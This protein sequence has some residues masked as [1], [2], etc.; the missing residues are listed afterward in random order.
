MLFL[1][2]GVGVVWSTQPHASPLEKSWLLVQVLAFLSSFAVLAGAGLSALV[3]A[4]RAMLRPLRVRDESAP[5]AWATG[6][7]P[8][9]SLWAAS[10][11]WLLVSVP[12]HFHNTELAA[13]LVVLLALTLGVLA[14]SLGSVLTGLAGRAR[15][16]SARL[17]LTAYVLPAIFVSCAAWGS[18]LWDNRTGLGQLSGWLLASAAAG[19]IAYIAAGVWP[20]TGPSFKARVV[21]VGIALLI[22]GSSAL[23]PWPAV[24]L[25][26][27]SQGASQ[28]IVGMLR[29]ASD[30][31]GDGYS[32]LWMGGDCAPFDPHVH[33]G[34]LEI[35]RDGID[36][37]CLGGDSKGIAAIAPP[38]WQA[39]PAGLPDKPN[40]LLISIETLRADRVS[41][42]GFKRPTTPNLEA[43]AKDAYVFENYFATTPWTRL[44]LPA[45]FSSRPPTRIHWE[46][47]PK[48]H[49]WLASTTP[50]LPT[51][52]LD[53][54]YNTI[55]VLAS[56][57][58]FTHVE[59]IGFERGFNTYD[60]STKIKYRGGTLHG[61][62]GTDQA[63]LV[64]KHFERNKQ[65][66]FFLW[67]HLL[68]PH[69]LYERAERAPNFGDDRQGLYDSEIWEADAVV[70]EILA[71]LK[72][73]GLTDKT[74]VVVV[75]DHG[76]EFQE[77]G[78]DWHGGNLYQPQVHTAGLIHVPGM[79][80]GRIKQ[81][82]SHEDLAPT[83][84]NLA[85]IRRGFAD[86]AGRDL[87]GLLRGERLQRDHF[88]LERYDIRSGKHFMAALV[89]YP[90][91]LI[92]TEDGQQYELFDLKR[93]P[94]EKH[95]LPER[96]EPFETL[97]QELRL[98]VDGAQR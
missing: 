47:A 85:G 51:L 91:K 18:A 38:R 94:A 41:F 50:W 90:Y 13:L 80:G 77:H 87:L 56:L 16:S 8:V 58:A 69:Y 33:P 96:G 5:S 42:L 17:F 49:P 92:Y 78:R 6:F 20:S 70:G 23:A 29:D 97:A 89:H 71:D 3:S 86:M 48:K 43:Y 57:T 37:N 82:V 24:A 12:E 9:L 62:P 66:P 81:A 45:I 19:L 88:F 65:R 64:R 54:G 72:T 1:V 60:T 83:L 28:L 98:H 79:P 10:L 55:A 25:V 68:E 84:L 46:K 11:Y 67:V 14:C 59:A 34:A 93:D 26:A 44:S 35:P 7:G 39:R 73:S 61:F 31:D 36:N 63:K 74:I 75:G 32:A 40:V 15:D 52:F 30:F 4:V 21:L 22:L 95:P 76:E 2:D 27:R 53:Q